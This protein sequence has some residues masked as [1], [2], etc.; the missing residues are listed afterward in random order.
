MEPC[1]SICMFVQSRSC[2]SE[3]QTRLWIYVYCDPCVRIWKLWGCPACFCSDHENL[4]D[5]CSLQ[6]SPLPPASCMLPPPPAS[7]V[8]PPTSQLWGWHCPQGVPRRNQ[9]PVLPM[10]TAKMHCQWVLP[11]PKG[12]ANGLCQ[13]TLPMGAANGC[14]Q[15]QQALQM[16]AANGHCQHALPVG[17]AYRHCQHNR[18]C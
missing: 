18:H 16:D 5:L 7:P 12:V 14:C 2:I 6:P 3:G 8:P 4:T 11:M 13:Q 17:S 9:Q 1:S 15:C 10:G